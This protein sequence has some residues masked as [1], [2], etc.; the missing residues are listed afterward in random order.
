MT[1][2][3]STGGERPMHDR[4]H[5]CAIP[6]PSLLIAPRALFEMAHTRCFAAPYHNDIGS[7]NQGPSR[8]PYTLFNFYIQL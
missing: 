1:I 4:Q 3:Q 6:D 2:T 5:A 8:L 7:T